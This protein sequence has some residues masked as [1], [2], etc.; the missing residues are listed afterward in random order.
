M[1]AIAVEVRA[2]IVRFYK[3]TKD[4]EQTCAVF[5]VSESSVY[6]FVRKSRMGISL[7]PK[8]K[9]QPLRFS[10]DQRSTI[11]EWATHESASVVPTT[12]TL[13]LR[14]KTVSGASISPRTVSRILYL[15]TVYY[16][17]TTT[18]VVVDCGVEMSTVT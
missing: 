11:R 7:E 17:V 5:G 18:K 8:P 2:A 13:A 3:T 4:V 12:K 1:R 16:V 10:E 9:T 15:S 6:S 14:F